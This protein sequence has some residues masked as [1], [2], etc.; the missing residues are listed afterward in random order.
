MDIIR[1]KEIL[2]ILADGINP[3]TGEVLSAQDSCNQPDVIRALNAVLAN[4]DTPKT[5]NAPENAGKPWS[6]A[7]DT[8]LCQMFDAGKTRKEMCIHFGR[9]K[10][11]IKARLAKLGKIEDTYYLSSR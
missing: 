9:S 3:M 6:K 8:T 10:D 5:S 7:D 1:A 2:T 4:L 11:A